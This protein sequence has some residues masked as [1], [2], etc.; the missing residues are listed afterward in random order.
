MCDKIIG[1]LVDRLAVGEALKMVVQ[2]LPVERVR[3]IP[4]DGSP[5]FEREMRE[6]LVIAV[7]V[8]GDH[9]SGPQRLADVL[10]H[11]GFS[12]AGATSDSN[13]QWV[14]GHDL[15]RRESWGC[16]PTG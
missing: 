4:V 16:R 1:G 3:M 15:E 8:D 12:R 13:D 2:Q 11:G 7:H 6:V 9:R 5:L 14:C 10:R